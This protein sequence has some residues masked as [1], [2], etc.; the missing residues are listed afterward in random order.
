MKRCAHIAF[1]YSAKVSDQAPSFRCCTD[2]SYGISGQL[3]VFV[4]SF[5]EVL[6]C[7]V[8]S[9]KTE[10]RTAHQLVFSETYLH[11]RSF[12]QCCCFSWRHK[13]LQYQNPYAVVSTWPLKA[14]AHPL[15]PAGQRRQVTTYVSWTWPNSVISGNRKQG[16]PNCR[17]A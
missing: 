13:H 8:L 7:I 1:K 16:D 15:E 9:S 2:W 14:P 3:S 17:T 6:F 11:K 12:L 10:S 5:L 4:C